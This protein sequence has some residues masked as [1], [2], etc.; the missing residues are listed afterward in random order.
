VLV[1]NSGSSS[2]K[3]AL[4]DPD[5]GDRLLV[6]IAERLGGSDAVLRLSSDGAESRQHELDG[7]DHRGAVEEI[8]RAA[9]ELPADQQP[10]SVGHRVVHGGER[11]TES[12]VITPEVVAA[13]EEFSPLAPLHNP[14]NLLGIRAV[15]AAW[16]E[17]PQ[18]A[19]FDTSFHQTMPPPAYRYAVPEEW[20]ADHGVRR[21]GFHG[22]SHRYV[23]ERA[24]DLLHRPIAEL[25]LVVAHLGNGCSATAVLGGRSVDT[26]MGL[27]PLEGLVMGT[28]SGD[29]DPALFGYLAS[30][31]ALTAAE[32]T[33]LLNRRSGL[34]GLSG[35]GNDMREIQTAARNGDERARLA[36]DV[37]VHRLAKHLAGLVVGLG[38]LDGLVFTGGIGENA[39]DIRARTV[40]A[41]GFLGLQLDAV[42]NDVHGAGH[43]GRVSTGPGPVVLVVPTDEE[44]MIALDTR[45][46]TEPGPSGGRR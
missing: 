23:S 10:T 20:Y 30:E 11:F 24:A 13:I 36:V 28:R 15:S 21:Y 34:L 44:L 37:F 3:F 4:I 40:E 32:V 8:L 7:G 43:S 25:A 26:T 14:A 42:A 16:P 19:V 41:L 5:S 27:T 6:G 46:L 22:T 18:V 17:V 2:V 9:R 31:A 29:V 1:I 12:V 38:R 45:R 35:L 39:A 33:D